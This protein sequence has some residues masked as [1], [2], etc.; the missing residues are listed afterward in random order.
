MLKDMTLKELIPDCYNSIK[1]PGQSYLKKIEDL[2]DKGKFGEA[3]N[4][5]IKFSNTS[6]KVEIKESGKSKPVE[7]EIPLICLGDKMVAT[8]EGVSDPWYRVNIYRDLAKACVGLNNFAEA[9]KWLRKAEDYIANFYELTINRS[10]PNLISFAGQANENDAKQIYILLK[11]TETDILDAKCKSAEVNHLNKTKPTASDCKAALD[12]IL[13]LYNLQ[14]SVLGETPIKIANLFDN[15]TGKENNPWLKANILKGIGR[16]LVGIASA[17]VKR[18]DN[19]IPLSIP[20]NIRRSLNKTLDL[21]GNDRLAEEDGKLSLNEKLR[22]I[23]VAKSKLCEALIYLFSYYGPN[24]N[25]R[26]ANNISLAKIDVAGSLD[27]TKSFALFKNIVWEYSGYIRVSD[28]SGD[29][30]KTFDDLRH[31]GYIDPNGKILSAFKIG[32]VKKDNFGTN[33]DSIWNALISASY[34]SDNGDIQPKFDGILSSFN[35][36]EGLD[37]TSKRRAFSVLY[38][39]RNRQIRMFLQKGFS[40]STFELLQSRLKKK[41]PAIIRSLSKLYKYLETET[42]NTNAQIAFEI[43]NS[44]KSIKD[45]NE[46]KYWTQMLKL[47]INSAEQS[48]M[49]LRRR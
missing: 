18:G 14:M 10:T 41:N 4:S 39:H 46:R 37:D 22:I 25:I 38:A 35:R 49:L 28:F 7:I 12:E 27:R 36:I 42:R 1:G 15:V 29:S 26:G 2:L 40:K 5:L 19:Y 9:E 16:A 3:Y 34:I 47:H 24:I 30:K 21:K 13:P 48:T 33:R 17:A 11:Y 20:V 23:N 8:V 44:L 43:N 32:D 45:K 6:I 31:H